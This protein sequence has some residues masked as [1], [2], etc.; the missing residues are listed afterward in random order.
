MKSVVISSQHSPDVDQSQVRELLRPYMLKSIP[1]K[2]LKRREISKQEYLKALD[3]VKKY[4][5]NQ[6]LYLGGIFA[7]HEI[8]LIQLEILPIVVRNELQ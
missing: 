4:Q 3:V 2:F 7:L 8:P 1:E 6:E 5:K